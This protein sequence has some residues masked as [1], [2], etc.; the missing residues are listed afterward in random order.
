MVEAGGREQDV[1][2]ENV[3]SSGVLAQARTVGPPVGEMVTLHLTPDQALWGVVRWVEGL[4]FGVEVDASAP[5][6]AAEPQAAESA[7]SICLRPTRR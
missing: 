5:A 6:T 3:S 1:V 2:V 4:R 7:Q